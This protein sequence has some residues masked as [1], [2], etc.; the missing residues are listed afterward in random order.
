M[1]RLAT[2]PPDPNQISAA[3]ISSRPA[4]T[5][6]RWPPPAPRSASRPRTHSR[7]RRRQ[8][9]MRRARDQPDRGLSACRSL[10]ARL[11]RRFHGAARIRIGGSPRRPVMTSAPPAS[12]DDA[13]SPA[14]R[15]RGRRVLGA[16]AGLLAAAAALGA[17]ELVAGIVGTAGSPVLA[18]GNAAIALTP[19]AGEGLRDRHVRPATT[20]PPW[21]SGTLILLAALRRRDRAAGP[22]QPPASASW[23]SPCSG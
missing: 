13:A 2:V 18:V 7:W 10:A 9:R 12:R 11:S 21:S 17:A 19:G 20:R 15:R 3:L 6:S 14:A 4:S 16:L 1:I 23:A 22:A 8:V 5:P